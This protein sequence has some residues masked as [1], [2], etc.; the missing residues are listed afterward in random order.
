MVAQPHQHQKGTRGWRRVPE[1]VPPTGSPNQSRVLPLAG[2]SACIISGEL[3]KVDDSRINI[4]VHCD[5]WEGTYRDKDVYI[6][7]LN[8]PKY[9]KV[10]EI[11][12]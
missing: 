1:A 12:L 9:K 4:N 10:K 7:S 11:G 2:H 6:M 3:V 8:N 5:L